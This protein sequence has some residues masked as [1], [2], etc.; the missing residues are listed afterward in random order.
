MNNKTGHA[1]MESK[2]YAFIKS[3]LG[4]VGI[5]FTLIVLMTLPPILFNFMLSSRGPLNEAFLQ[6]EVE[7][8]MTTK[9]LA[10]RLLEKG[11]I[12]N[13]LVFNIYAKMYGYDVQIKSGKYLVS[14]SMS[15]VEIIEKMV[16]GEVI[17]DDVRVTIPEGIT[18]EQIAQIFENNGL[19]SKEEFLTASKPDNFK[20]E[21]EFL[22]DFPQNSDL[23]GFLFPDTYFL[24]KDKPAQYYVEVLLNQFKEVCIDNLDLLSKSEDTGLS[25]RET[26]VLASIV[27]AEAKLDNEK[28][29]IAGVFYNRIKTRKPLESCATVE[30]ALKEHKE[31]LTLKDLE[32]ESPYNTYKYV[33]LPPGP[34][35]VPG[36]KSIAAAVN[37]EDVEFL[38]FVANGDGSHTFSKTFYDHIKATKRIQ[39]VK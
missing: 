3:P 8:G 38:Y 36:L 14:P 35:G 39:G 26:I 31:V 7:S 1:P 37:P 20:G 6:F 16:S 23:E 15:S 28:P 11:I 18:L 32:I 25:L 2:T 33:G 30:Y 9:Q 4:R 5:T 24:P 34:I 10:E 27:E 13:P 29:I 22:R 19:V 12:K 17:K 21:Y